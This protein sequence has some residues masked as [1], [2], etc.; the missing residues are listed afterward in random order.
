MSGAGESCPFCRLPLACALEV[1][2]EN[3]VGCMHDMNSPIGRPPVKKDSPQTASHLLSDFLNETRSRDITEDTPG[4]LEEVA[5]RL[6]EI[7][8]SLT[9]D[10]DEAIALTIQ[11]EELQQRI[12][13]EKKHEEMLRDLIAKEKL[14]KEEHYGQVLHQCPRCEEFMTISEL[15]SLDSCNHRFCRPCLRR[16]CVG[17]VELGSGDPIACPL[18]G[19]GAKLSHRDIKDVLDEKD[20]Q[21]YIDNA[22][23]GLIARDSSYSKCP[24][25]GFAVERVAS[26]GNE[27]QTARPPQGLDGRPLSSAAVEHYV[28]FRLRC[29]ESRTE[30]CGGCG[31]TPYHLGFTCDEFAA[32]QAGK[33]CRFC[34]V[35]LTRSNSAKRTSSTPSGLRN[36]C[37][38]D[39]CLRKRLES[40]GRVLPCGH[41]CV[42]IRGDS[43]EFPGKDDWRCP[44]C[45]DPDCGSRR[46]SRVRQSTTDFC[47]I[48]WVEELGSSPCLQL[49]CGHVF[50]FDCVLEKLRRRWNGH[51]ITF[52]FM[53]CPLCSKFID[54]NALSS[55][56]APARNLYELVKSKA[57]QRLQYE[58]LDSSQSLNG[59]DA[60]EVSLA[61]YSYFVCFKCKKPY[62]GGHAACEDENVE[63]NEEELV[64]G[65]CSAKPSEICPTHQTDYIV[66]KC[67][68]CC[69]IATWYCWGTTHFCNECHKKAS[70]I[71][72]K[73]PSLLPSC[74]CGLS[75]PPNGT[76]HCMGCYMCH[77]LRQ[78]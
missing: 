64:C 30:F 25:C 43:G 29:P 17:V 32:Y 8:S 65:G 58:G 45:I 71:A 13:D 51:R 44:K 19:C 53:K 22:V 49:K 55:E 2:I 78:F 24:K 66:Y 12:A 69:E 60:V 26:V 16:L 14:E 57:L 9:P 10:S 37:N 63:G 4:S 75:H 3:C 21:Q 42:G 28:S 70:V 73:D 68:F 40:C 31:E 59:K 20:Y 11:M 67:R 76:E 46:S 1:H 48:C 38:A 35:A 39:E 41:D 72:R 15:Y 34:A 56:L 27:A 74:T 5:R 50:H 18:L 52:T 77:M 23:H 62:F 61:K 36:V 7:G 54:H 33:K 6:F 47:N